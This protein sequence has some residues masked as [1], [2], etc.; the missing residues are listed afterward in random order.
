MQGPKGHLLKIVKFLEYKPTNQL[1]IE[2]RD[3]LRKRANYTLNLR[4]TR[5]LSQKS[6]GLHIDSYEDNNGMKQ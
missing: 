5:N 1:Y 4:F 3:K 2:V 6:E